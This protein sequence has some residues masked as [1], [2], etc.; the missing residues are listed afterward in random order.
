MKTFDKKKAADKFR[1]EVET[2]VGAGIHTPDAETTTFA[3][4]AE[5]WLRDRER[6]GKLTGVPGLA[7]QQ[8]AEWATRVHLVPAFGRVLV[9]KITGEDL[10]DYFENRA[11]VRSY[12]TLHALKKFLK[13]ILTFAVRQKLVKRNVLTDYGVKNPAKQKRITVPSLD[14]VAKIVAALESRQH[15]GHPLTLVQ[16]RCYVS[17][18]I[19]GGL[20]LGEIS[21]LQWGSV[22]FASNVIRVVNSYSVPLTGLKGPKTEAGI[23]EIAMAPPVRY[24]MEELSRLQGGPSAGYCFLSRNGRP[25][26]TG[27]FHAGIW[28]PLL[29][30]AG[31]LIPVDGRRYG[32]TPFHFHALRH[33]NVSMLIAE[34]LPGINIS[35]HI[36]H[37]NVSTTMDIYG[38]LFPEDQRVAN[39]LTTIASR[40]DATWARHEAITHST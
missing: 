21:G 23:R 20:R 10:E 2:E 16:R 29:A 3:K 32:K 6:R 33:V 12:H 31:L 8:H 17:L 26:S 30:A 18:A 40:F 13:L 15:Y 27:S 9:S 14:G 19:F 7:A 39:S 37:S 4:V 36:G 1:T 5:L 11:T 28:K 25:Y 38:H 24:A 34:G 22:D 35:R